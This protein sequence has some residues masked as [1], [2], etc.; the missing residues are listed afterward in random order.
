[1][2]E[3]RCWWTVATRTEHHR[4]DYG[5]SVYYAITHTNT[6]H[7]QAQQTQQ[8]HTRTHIRGEGMN[9]TGLDNEIMCGIATVILSCGLYR[10]W[11]VLD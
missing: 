10:K 6:T 4:G 8:T 2:A 11:K 9:W 7:T 5:S 1:M 3:W